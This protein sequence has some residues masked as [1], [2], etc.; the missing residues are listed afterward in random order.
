LG[1]LEYEG[2]TFRVENV[3]SVADRM[4]LKGRLPGFGQVRL[5]YFINGGMLYCAVIVVEQEASWSSDEACWDDCAYLCHAKSV[6]TQVIRTV[7]GISQPTGL[8]RFHSLGKLE[9]RGD[10]D[11]IN[12]RHGGNIFFR[13]TGTAVHNR[14]WCYDE[15]CDRFW[16]GVELKTD[17]KEELYYV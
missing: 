15:F 13:Q 8:K 4:I 17:K 5:E 2:A 12:L 16:W 11:S 9:L 6:D 1:A 14:L 10:R 7:S 3:S